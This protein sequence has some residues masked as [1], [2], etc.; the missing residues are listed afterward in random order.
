MKEKQNTNI[1]DI[2]D[3]LNDFILV[4]KSN[5][6]IKTNQDIVDLG[7]V[8]KSNLSKAING[9]SKYLTKSLIKKITSHFSE[10]KYSFEDIW[11]GKDSNYQ[12]TTLNKSDKSSIKNKPHDEQ[13]EILFRKIESL[14]GQIKNGKDEVS[15]KV[16]DVIDLI[17]LYLSPIAA[18]FGVEVDPE[19]KKKLLDHIN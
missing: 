8:A 16:N 5:K 4:L 10:S 19:I 2:K 11:Y 12:E 9:D 18:K 6:L 7:I 14:E 17:E 1:D 13:M 15:E 3:R